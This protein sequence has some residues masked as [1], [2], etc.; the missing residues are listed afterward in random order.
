M[1][2]RC[3]ASALGVISLATLI[4]ALLVISVSTNRATAATSAS[5]DVR[6]QKQHLRCESMVERMYEYLDLDGDGTVSNKEIHSSDT[7]S[8]VGL[9]DNDRHDLVEGCYFLSQMTV[10]DVQMYLSRCAKNDMFLAHFSNI[11][12]AEMFGRLMDP[13]VSERSMAGMLIPAR[14]RVA[15][16]RWFFKSLLKADRGSILEREKKAKAHHPEITDVDSTQLTVH[17]PQNPG[18]CGYKVQ[19]CQVNDGKAA[20]AN[21]DVCGF[22]W[23]A[24]Y[25]TAGV[26]TVYLYGL[27]PRHTY[28]IRVRSFYC[29]AGGINSQIVEAKT[30]SAN[31]KLASS[32]TSR[33]G[34]SAEWWARLRH[35]IKS[36][37][38]KLRRI[39]ATRDTILLAWDGGCRID[40]N[41][42]QTTMFSVLQAGADEKAFHEGEKSSSSGLSDQ[43]C[44]AG[45]SALGDFAVSPISWDVLYKRD[46]LAWS[47]GWEIA[48]CAEARRV[49]NMNDGPFTCFVKDLKEGRRYRFK[50]RGVFSN[51]SFVDAPVATST[52]PSP[53]VIS[54]YTVEVESEIK[55]HMTGCVDDADC[56]GEKVCTS[57][58]KCVKPDFSWTNLVYIVSSLLVL[59]MILYSYFVPGALG[60][61]DYFLTLTKNRLDSSDQITDSYWYTQFRGRKTNKEGD[62]LHM[63]SL[64][65]HTQ[66]RWKNNKTVCDNFP[67]QMYQHQFL[68][69]IRNEMF[70]VE[71]WLGGGSFGRV[72]LARPVSNRRSGT[73]AAWVKQRFGKKSLKWVPTGGRCFAIKFLD[74][75]I[76]AQD[77]EM[78]AKSFPY[79]ENVSRP[80]FWL[81]GGWNTGRDLHIAPR[82]PFFVVPY[83]PLGDLSQYIP[84]NKIDRKPLPPRFV[85]RIAHQALK[86]LQHMHQ[87]GFI[88][89]DIKP[90]NLMLSSE[91]ILKI[92]DFGEIETFTSPATSRR[93]GND[94][95]DPKYNDF[96]HHETYD[97][98]LRGTTM[99]H[100]PELSLPF[101]CGTTMKRGKEVQELYT[102][103]DRGGMRFAY[104]KRFKYVR[105]A[106]TQEME[107]RL[108]DT[109]CGFNSKVDVYALGVSLLS[110]A[111]GFQLLVKE[112]VTPQEEKRGE[113]A[114]RGE[115]LSCCELLGSLVYDDDTGEILV[116]KVNFERLGRYVPSE[117][118]HW[119]RNEDGSRK[120]GD[121][122]F[123]KFIGN[124]VCNVGKRKSAFELL[125]KKSK[126][127]QNSWLRSEAA[128][129]SAG[130][131]HSIKGSASGLVSYPKEESSDEEFCQTLLD[132][133]TD[134]EFIE[135]ALKYFPTY[136]FNETEQKYLALKGS[137]E[138][139]V[140]AYSGTMAGNSCGTQGYRPEQVH[141][142]YTILFDKLK[143]K[144][145]E[146]NKRV[147]ELKDIV[148]SD[149]DKFLMKAWPDPSPDASE[150]EK[151]TAAKQNATEL[152][153]VV[154]E[155]CESKNIIHA[156]QLDILEIA[157]LCLAFY[158]GK[159]N[160]RFRE[161]Y[162]STMLTKYLQTLQSQFELVCAQQIHSHAHSI[163]A[164]WSLPL[165]VQAKWVESPKCGWVWMRKICNRSN[166][167]RLATMESVYSLRKIPDEKILSSV[168][169]NGH[170]ERSDSVES[171]PS[172][173]VRSE[174]ITP[175]SFKWSK[176]F[177]ILKDDCLSCYSNIVE[178]ILEEHQVSMSEPFLF[179][180]LAMLV[181]HIQTI[182]THTLSLYLII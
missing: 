148:A 135:D 143:K 153:K 158:S 11:D 54:Q 179:G 152:R 89:L 173:I 70:S 126:Q 119:I 58:Y 56:Y 88:H 53:S 142:I 124:M 162:A 28:K 172:S 136:V 120:V 87:H 151:K 125:T 130:A 181:H 80:R 161:M 114:H 81:P 156:A 94:D 97:S 139:N 2:V 95:L 93:D 79:H 145:A 168:V 14:D 8:S 107:K 170:C 77:V 128:E 163:S 12:G 75:A 20:R 37:P 96:V 60:S 27:L 46:E 63:D 67:F 62:L 44:Q 98:G 157:Q 176:F 5:S 82:N 118:R 115:R 112:K 45:S 132:H 175:D 25:P 110:M 131:Q 17:L 167:K 38:P 127:N 43:V 149:V 16:R 146:E 21:V 68:M 31:K 104:S 24:V 171:I 144:K 121:G 106:E 83:L 117:Y 40:S 73:L 39:S 34:E 105:N 91:G 103:H 150:K 138:P 4:A 13:A 33:A 66:H 164:E 6:D 51:A 50:V 116:D 71:K 1:A 47:G 165:K 113:V 99:F 169:N 7:L 32:K 61:K 49:D 90:G 18:A 26:A 180:K 134:P 109:T 160:R 35:Q 177:M 100:A 52:T 166:S 133:A 140:S 111:C 174:H 92:V 182:M 59:A 137:H 76:G 15:L 72:F 84:K 74:K 85:R 64:D 57:S 147:T 159:R 108:E 41:V 19:Y 10:E 141:K 23:S 122:D 9:N 36:N 155:Y 86:G 123:V 69:S 154:S 102:K 78:I 55:R 22:A 3:R 30:R 178:S 129:V 101:T 42:L 65:Q 48:G 29:D